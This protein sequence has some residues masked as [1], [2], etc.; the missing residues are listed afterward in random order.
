MGLPYGVNVRGM[1]GGIH[2][3]RNQRG[4][5]SFQPFCGGYQGPFMVRHFDQVQAGRPL[6]GFHLPLKR[7]PSSHMVTHPD[8]LSVV[9]YRQPDGPTGVIT[10]RLRAPLKPIFAGHARC[11]SV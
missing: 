6:F 8:Q 4:G 3:K 5:S 2:E 11:W 7:W 10:G 1:G 9:T